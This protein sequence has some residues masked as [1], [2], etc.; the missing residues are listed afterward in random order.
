MTQIDQFESIFRAADKTLYAYQ[1]P[2]IRKILVVTDLTVKASEAFLVQ[3]QEFL[4]VLSVPKEPKWVPVSGK[5]FKSSADLLKLVKKHKP[6]LICTYRNLQSAGWKY[7]HS[8]GEHLDV[9]VQ[10]ADVPVMIL[11]HPEAG[12]ADRHAMQNTNRVMVLTDHLSDSHDL[13]NIAVRLTREKGRLS[14]VH[15][16]DTQVFER[17]IDAISK[18]ATIDTDEA[19]EKIKERLLKEPRDYIASCAA[20]LASHDVKI[21][22]RSVVGFGHHITAFKKK[23]D[24]QKLDLIVMRGKDKTQMAMH[25]IVYPL[26]VE[27]R[28]IPLLLI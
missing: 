6:D 16:E 7:P 17:Y 10:L 15:L 1:M 26:A 13:V 12:R 27:I 25:G 28:Q 3:L 11:P 2:E 8:L 24:K 4:S 19:R 23:I 5:D 21:K 22:I 14:L 18:I 20:V 9:L